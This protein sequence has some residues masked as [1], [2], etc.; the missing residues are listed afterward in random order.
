M[1]S[2]NHY[3]YLEK[4]SVIKKN[5]ILAI[6]IASN[7][8]QPILISPKSSVPTKPMTN[9]GPGAWHAAS[10]SP[11]CL[12]DNSLFFVISETVTAPTGNP[13]ND[14]STYALINRFHGAIFFA[15]IGIFNN[16]W[17]KII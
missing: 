5:K 2:S 11:P 14:P 6:W 3:P 1:L 13:P 12:C 4:Y 9:I 16:H 10:R 7:N 17:V 15:L 8:F